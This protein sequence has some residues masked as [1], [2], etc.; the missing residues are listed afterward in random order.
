MQTIS[1]RKISNNRV[2][3]LRDFLTHL[4]FDDSKYPA[5]NDH[6]TR[7]IEFIDEALTHT[8]AR[9][10]INHERLEFLGDAVLRLVA[11][12]YI[13]RQFPSLSVGRRSAL[14]SQ[15]VSDRWLAEL[16][17]KL[18][19][20]DI[21]IVGKHAASDDFAQSTL[22]TEATEALIGGIYKYFDNLEPIHDWLSPYW[23]ETSK[24]VL[25]DPHLRNF[26]SA[27]QEWSQA[28]KLNIPLYEN[29]E[30]TKHHGDTKRFFSK[31]RIDGKKCGEG[32]GRSIKDAEQN[33]AQNA[34]KKISQ[35]HA[36]LG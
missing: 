9:L 29:K 8:S 22:E 27:L 2:S 16:G 30:R 25:A 34:L 32:W 33:A 6:L 4:G 21:L 23:E 18:G 1:S 12:E 36:S 26:K 24:F 7:N 3:Q 35:N 28:K 5:K 10:T 17:K 19:I 31:V 11:S 13:D 20:R 14:R 15:L